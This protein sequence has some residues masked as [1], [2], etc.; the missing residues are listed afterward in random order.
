VLTPDFPPA[1]GGIQHVAHRLVTHFED[2]TCRVVT[3]D[4]PG[5]AAWDDAE[6]LDVHRVSR[7]LDRRL[8]IVGL[9]AVALAHAR[10]FR[11][12]VVVAVH[13]VAGPAAAAIRRIFGVPVVTYLHAAEAPASPRI[14]R[15]AMRNSDRVVAV[16]RY[17]AGL[18]KEAGADPPRIRVIPPGVDWQKLP[19]GE[20]R[21][22]PTVLTVARLEDRYKGHDVMTRAMPL[23]RSRV[24]GA[25]WVVVGGGSL[26]H[27]IER[28]A[29]AQGVSDAIRLC[30]TVSDAERDEW[31]DRSHVFAMPSREPAGGGAGEGFG[32]VYLEAGVHGMPVVAGGVGGALDAVVD[33]V[34]GFL[35]DPT[36]HVQVA[37][38]I[39]RL[40]I[41]RKAAAR[42]GEVASD[43]ARDF[44]WF[45]IARR[46]EDLLVEAVRNP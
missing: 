35:I 29:E 25:Q 7:A 19:R 8:G 22:T 37:D 36:D 28:L 2:V 23:V 4:A 12:H 13:I 17:T 46:V 24:P 38:A 11:P 31:L 32:I 5:A 15:F 33:G 21:S 20:R 44:S 1:P 16:S 39:T 27:D 26:Q 9:N 18:A 43:R 14:A 10:R 30:G 41:D 6:G 40:L 42:M 45:K 34:T 3:L